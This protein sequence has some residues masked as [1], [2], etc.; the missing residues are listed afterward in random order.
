MYSP[1]QHDADAR[2]SRDPPPGEDQ[3]AK[4]G[5]GV[6]HILGLAIFLQLHSSWELVHLDLDHFFF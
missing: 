6:D 1:S 5:Q 3:E 4:C 2:S